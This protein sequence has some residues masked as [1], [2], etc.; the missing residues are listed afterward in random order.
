VRILTLMLFLGS[1]FN[2]CQNNS[3]SAEKS[4]EEVKADSKISSII[5]NP[6]TA[7]EPV[8]T[9]NVAKITFDND[10]YN[11]GEVE[12][13][14]IVEHTFSFTNTGKVPLVISNARSTCGCTVPEWPKEPIAPGAK[15]DILIKFNTKN[16]KRDQTKPV[17]ITAN[18]YPS[19]S[20][21]FVAGFVKPSPEEKKASE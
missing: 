6:V 5:R 11:F 10:T 7:N 18:T 3:N 1:L 19:T 14:E 12:E 13:G 2:A 9:V 16:K 20:K 15:G 17:T 8:D 4:I 21:V